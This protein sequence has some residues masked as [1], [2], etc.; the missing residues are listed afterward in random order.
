MSNNNNLLR[1]YHLYTRETHS[2]L[3]NENK[4]IFTDG[5]IE[6][7]SV[8]FKISLTAHTIYYNVPI[9]WT[10]TKLLKKIHLWILTDFGHLNEDHVTFLIEMC[11]EIPDVRPE[12]APCL[13]PDDTITYR[14]KFILNNKWPSFYVEVNAGQEE[15]GGVGVGLVEFHY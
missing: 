7:V 14:E 4:K 11:Q 6:W 2:Q 13:P 5:D 3:T 10:I 1:Q 9:H 8:Y 12:D 15:G